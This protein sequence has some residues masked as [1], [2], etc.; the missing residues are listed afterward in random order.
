MGHRRMASR[1][2]KCATHVPLDQLAVVVS[3]ENRYLLGA[4]VAIATRSRGFVAE[5]G[6][7]RA[8]SGV[9]SL[10]EALSRPAL[11]YIAM[12]CISRR[13]PADPR[14][15]DQY[16]NRLAWWSWVQSSRLASGSYSLMNRRLSSSRHYILSTCTNA[17]LA[18]AAAYDRVITGWGL[19]S[20]ARGAG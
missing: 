18:S 9:T 17:L 11:P 13:D 8:L 14:P 7:T 2:R 19:A 3:A 10:A 12:A 4:P 1:S 5:R 20:R 15:H 16:Q 6:C